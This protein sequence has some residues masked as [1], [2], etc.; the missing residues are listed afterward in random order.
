[1]V[2]GLSLGEE[3]YTIGLFHLFTHAFF[4]ALLFLGAGS[5]IHAVH[6]NN[7]SE[8]G[9]LRKYMP[10]TYVTFLIGSLALAGVPPFAGF[11]SKDEII[12]TAFHSHHYAIW[13]VAL[14]TAI[15]TAFYV[16]RMVLLTFFGEY[17]GHAVHGE[18]AD[19][20]HAAHPHE[21]PRAITWPLIVLA[22]ASC[23]VGFLNASAFHIHLFGDW[24]HIGTRFTPEAFNYGFALVS[25][26]G[27]AAGIVV[28]YRLYARWRERDPLRRLGPAY[29]VLERKY[30]LDDL[31][32]RGIVRPIQYPIAAAVYWTNQHVL[33]GVVNGA[34]WATRRLGLGVNTVDREVVDGAVNGVGRST[35]WLGRRAREVQTGQV[36]WYAAA[37]FVG[38]GVLALAITLISRFR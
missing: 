18:T 33:D 3:G 11:W 19:A 23:G 32:L 17:R 14:I 9:G 1:M 26:I 38:V 20:A 35:R 25:L 15:L 27:A 6:T 21:S 16:T 5:V 29:D 7:M 12:S 37:L 22:A 4:K 8:M 30:Y 24:V 2:A 34:A 10:V 31:Y 36:Q 13:A 28:G